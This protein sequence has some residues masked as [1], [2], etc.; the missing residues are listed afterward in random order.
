MSGAGTGKAQLNTTVPE[1]LERYIALRAQRLGWAKTR[2][3]GEVLLWWAQNGAKPVSPADAL[4][5]PVPYTG[6]APKI[7]TTEGPKMGEA[8]PSPRKTRHNAATGKSG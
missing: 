4:F 2:F 5:P 6:P 1:E 3:A 7:G 8:M